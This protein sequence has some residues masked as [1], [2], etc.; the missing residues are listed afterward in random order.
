MAIKSDSVFDGNVPYFTVMASD[1]GVGIKSL[2]CF[3]TTVRLP[4]LQK[5]N[6][7]HT[8]PS[9]FAPPPDTSLWLLAAEV[10]VEKKISLRLS[11]KL[12]Y[13]YSVSEGVNAIICVFQMGKAL[14]KP[15]TPNSLFIAHSLKCSIIF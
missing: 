4:I 12:K 3:I 15:D 13:S 5:F 11:P 8:N 9:Q 7:Q 14:L 10:F 6:Y 1:I 2:W